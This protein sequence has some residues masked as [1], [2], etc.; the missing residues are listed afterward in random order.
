METEEKNVSIRIVKK[1]L[2]TRNLDLYLVIMM[3]L[4]AYA[5]VNIESV[6]DGIMWY[7]SFILTA[8]VFSLVVSHL[9]Q[10]RRFFL[11]LLDYSIYN[12]PIPI[13]IWGIGA[14]FILFF[15]YLS[16]GATF[17]WANF[18]VMLHQ[19][20]VA[21]AET[22]IFCIFLPEAYPKY[23]GRIPFKFK[24]K[25]GNKVIKGYQRIPGWFWAAGVWFGL[26]HFSV[27]FTGDWYQMIMRTMVATMFGLGWY[28]LYRYGETNKYLGGAPA[29]I[30]SH[31]VWNFL[32]ISATLLIISSLF[33]I[34]HPL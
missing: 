24:F 7:I 5:L 8:M 28:K 18:D 1:V 22:M 20:F 27:Y 26:F 17:V 4:E 3:A 21:S 2:E 15:M 25:M 10:E 29:V 13:A 34:F 23:W 33:P 14:F 30:A 19:L 16:M 12:V 6:F 31:W 32:A 9:K 11:K